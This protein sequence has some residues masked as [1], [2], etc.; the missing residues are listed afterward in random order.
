MSLSCKPWAESFAGS[1][2]PARAVV[3][4]LLLASMLGG[5]AAVAA[6]EQ[7]A[8]R[9]QAQRAIEQAQEKTRQIDARHAAAV[10]AC[11]DVFL[12]NQCRASARR[13]REQQLRLVRDREIAARAALRG[14]AAED[15]ER[16]RG[17]REAIT[18][19][20]PDQVKAP[21]PAP[22]QAEQ[23]RAAQ[24]R[25]RQTQFDAKQAANERQLEQRARQA[26]AKDAERAA[27]IKHYE[28]KQREAK[29][30]AE[31]QARIAAK[32]A[33]RRERRR[34]E[35]ERRAAEQKAAAH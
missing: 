32:N 35:R 5:G 11:R 8:T 24:A 1:M 28:D 30:R 18:P 27:N 12:V 6:A 33:E 15:R 25:Q 21:R 26:Q 23:E 2:A 14:F 4:S 10:Q 3:V 9:A 17:E 19:A 22:D 34:L 31:E 20:A 13:E 16:S 7:F 29:L